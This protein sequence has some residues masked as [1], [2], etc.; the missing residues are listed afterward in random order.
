MEKSYW[1]KKWQSGDIRFHR[2]VVHPALI[3]HFDL[4]PTRVMVPLCGKS[5]DL[6]WLKAQGHDVVGCEFNTKACID[7]FEE[8]HLSYQKVGKFIDALGLKFIMK[9]FLS[10]LRWPGKI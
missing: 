2:E 3:H 4:P 9:T 5:Q 7:F 1:D 6:L 10:C 8:N